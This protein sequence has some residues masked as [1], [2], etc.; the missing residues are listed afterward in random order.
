MSAPNRG[1][2]LTLD[3]G[4]MGRPFA[5]VTSSNEDAPPDTGFMGRPFVAA[6]TGVAPEP[7]SGSVRPVMFSV[8]T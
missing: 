5:L 7:P 1:E 2:A 4:F 6:P 8:S 3:V